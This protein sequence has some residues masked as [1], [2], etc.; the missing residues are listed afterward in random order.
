MQHQMHSCWD[1]DRASLDINPERSPQHT[2]GILAY[3]EWACSRFGEQVLPP[4]GHLSPLS[5]SIIDPRA[6]PRVQGELFLFHNP[7]FIHA[8]IEPGIATPASRRRR[9]GG[10]GSKS[11]TPRK[12]R[13]PHFLPQH[14]IA[15]SPLCSLRGL[16]ELLCCNL[17][18]WHKWF[19][20]KGC[21]S[22]CLSICLDVARTR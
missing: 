21:R 10:P 9:Y 11:L 14:I 13:A 7:L 19:S 5:V 4:I 2:I 16:P 12:T 18:F 20:V 1:I 3:I 8:L 6:C 15:S 17:A 22:I